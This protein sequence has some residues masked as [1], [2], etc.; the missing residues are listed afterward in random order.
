MSQMPR[1]TKRGECCIH[2]RTRAPALA[3]GNSLMTGLH[4]EE[5]SHV[6]QMCN[7][8]A[9]STSTIGT[10]SIPTRSDVHA[11]LISRRYAFAD[12]AAF[13]D[14]QHHLPILANGSAQ[15]G[16]S[17]SPKGA[18]GSARKGKSLYRTDVNTDGKPDSRRGTLL[19]KDSELTT[20]T[21]EHT[22]AVTVTYSEKFTEWGG[23][24]WRAHPR[25][26]QQR[27]KTS[28]FTPSARYPP[29]RTA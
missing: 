12:Q 21:L 13:L 19:L 9:D 25:S 4:I 11:A 5:A 6:L 8:S 29:P 28:R 1:A 14:H 10:M 26:Y 17:H 2:A 27:H 15:E 22:V 7:P 16:Q 24:R 18:N 3:S 20:E 23:G